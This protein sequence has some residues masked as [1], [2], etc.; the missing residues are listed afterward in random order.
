MTNSLFQWVL[1][2][3]N[4]SGISLSNEGF[5]NKLTALIASSSIECRYICTNITETAVIS[6]IAKALEFINKMKAQGIQFTL[7]DFGREHHL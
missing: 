6:N 1:L 7:D 4:L 2:T 3:I 5:I